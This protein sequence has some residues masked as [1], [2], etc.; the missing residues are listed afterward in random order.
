MEKKLTPELRNLKEEFDFTH[1]KSANQNGKLQQ[2][3][4][5]E[6]MW[7]EMNTIYY[8]TNSRHIEEVWKSQQKEL[9]MKLVKPI[10]NKVDLDIYV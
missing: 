4:M 1:K 8:M 2:C 10:W 3:S 7:S 9:E 6:N 5:D